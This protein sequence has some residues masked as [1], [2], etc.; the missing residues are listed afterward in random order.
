MLVEFR[1][2][3]F[4][5]IQDEQ[6]FSMVANTDKTHLDTHTS[7]QSQGLRLLK[8]SAIYGANAAGK[9]SFIK[10]I[11]IVQE[12]ILNSA[13]QQRGTKIPITPFL[14]DSDI[15][16]ASTFEITFLID[17]IRYQYGF[18]ATQ[19]RVLEEWLLVYMGTNIAQKWFERVYNDKSNKYEWSFSTKFLGQKKLWQDSTR[20]N[21]LF[22][23]TAVQ[24]NSTQLQP[25]FDW[26]REK[27]RVGEANS[28]SDD[29]VTIDMYKNEN[30]KKIIDL[31]IDNIK[32]QEKEFDEKDLPSDMPKEIKEIAMQELQGKKLLDISFIY[33][34]QQGEETSISLNK[35]SD[36][37]QRFFKLIVTWLYSLEN[38][39]II[40]IDDLHDHLHPLM[41]KFLIELFHNKDLNKSNAQLIFTTHETSVLNQDVFR[42]DQIWFCE[43]QNKATKLYPLSDFKQRKEAN[44]EDSYLA[45]RFG[46]LPPL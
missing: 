11:D 12:I 45:G 35:E 39:N 24:L 40:I 31:D 15:D 18:S 42:S 34:N 13:G 8:S 19:E 6:V 36:G 21:A 38:G 16:R 37:T 2:K 7:I 4:L 33:I 25:I 3:N 46:V 30:L 41:T 5:S 26:F 28:W 23:S 10:A 1:V 29:I 43:K 17:N 44:L 9:S 22:L 27:L 20:D 32:I 14:P